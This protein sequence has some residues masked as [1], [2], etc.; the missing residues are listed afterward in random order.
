M[1]KKLF[2]LLLFIG[3]ISA[4]QAQE[5]G[6]IRLSGALVYGTEVEEAGLNFG[7]EYF[8]TDQISGGVSYSIFFVPDPASFNVLNIDGRYYFLND[9]AQVYGLLGLANATSKFEGNVFGVPFSVKDSELGLNIG[10]GL[11]YMLSDKVGLNGQVK[12]TTP[13]DGQ[14]VLQGGVVVRLK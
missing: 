11:V 10:G 13:F 8:F 12:Y 6:A 3:I 1:I 4:A 7:G 5:K 9:K 14:L 2:S